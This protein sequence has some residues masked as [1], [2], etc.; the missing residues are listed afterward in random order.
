MINNLKVLYLVHD[1]ADP[2][3]LKRIQ[4]LTDGGA[5][6]CVA[7]FRRSGTCQPF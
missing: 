5:V 3:V 1:L 2:A 4:F 7:G 6:V